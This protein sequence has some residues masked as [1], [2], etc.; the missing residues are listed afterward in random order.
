MHYETIAEDCDLEGCQYR[1]ELSLDAIKEI[2]KISAD[3]SD[4]YGEYFREIINR[5]YALGVEHGKE[6]TRIKTVTN[7][8][9][10]AEYEIPEG[11]EIPHYEYAEINTELIKF[12]INTKHGQ[13]IVEAAD[14]KQA[15]QLAWNARNG[16]DEVYS[17]V[18]VV[19]DFHA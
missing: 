2:C 18:K 11:K 13:F 15:A 10:A 14:F 19:E 17:I 7:A 8:K 16:H 12:I 6:I 9:E 3:K 1:A 5:V 4:T